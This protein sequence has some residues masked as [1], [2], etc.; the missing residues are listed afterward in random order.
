MNRIVF[1][2]VLVALFTTACKEQTKQPLLPHVSGGMND[3]LLVMSTKNWESEP[4]EI[5]QEELTQMVPSIPGEE[6]IFDIIW[7]PHE[8]F[9]RVVKKQRNIIITKIGPDHKAK[10]SYHKSLWAQ[11]QMVIQ[12]A[13]PNQEEFIALF[14]KNKKEIINRLQNAELERLMDDYKKKSGK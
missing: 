3:V 2:I 5:V 9:T 6:T 13:A 12:I 14:N 8:A 7:M 10:V 11:S 4:G 1:Y